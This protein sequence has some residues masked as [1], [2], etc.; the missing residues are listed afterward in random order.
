MVGPYIFAF[1]SLLCTHPSQRRLPLLNN[2][3]WLL[4]VHCFTMHAVVCDCWL[5]LVFCWFPVMMIL[6]MT[7]MTKE[8]RNVRNVSSCMSFLCAYRRC[9]RRCSQVY[10]WTFLHDMFTALY[11][12]F[13]GTVGSFG[14]C[15]IA[16]SSLSLCWWWKL[17]SLMPFWSI[18]RHRLSSHHFYLWEKC[19]RMENTYCE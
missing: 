8:S 4:V 12:H 3:L 10:T 16:V 9:Y 6:I 15:F 1:F 19:F 18:F 13:E 11:Y 2:F 14:T 5:K 7:R 17:V